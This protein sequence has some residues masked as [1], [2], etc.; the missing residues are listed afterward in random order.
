MNIRMMAGTIMHIIITTITIIN[1]NASPMS[2]SS[3]DMMI[4]QNWFSPAFPTGAFSYS[5]GLETAIQDGLVT[6]ETHLQHWLEMLLVCGTGRND[7]LFIK[8]AYEGAVEAN[9]LCLALSAGKERQQES[10]ELARAFSQVVRASYD[11]CLPEGLAYPV[12]VGMAARQADIDMR[13][14]IQ[15]YLQGFVGN[16]I[17]VGVRAIPIGQQAGQNCLVGL[18][19]VIEQLMAELD[20]ASLDDVGSAAVMSDLMAMKHEISIP[21]IYRT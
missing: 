10:I 20:T 6:D 1:R 12:A 8:A 11:I 14:T 13:L 7:G 18:Y 9:R 3:R 17:S 5:H 19:P 21:R 15:S 4:L 16:L 2:D